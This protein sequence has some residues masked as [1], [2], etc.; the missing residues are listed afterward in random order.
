MRIRLR[1]YGCMVATISRAGSAVRQFDRESS[2]RERELRFGV[3]S[4]SGCDRELSGLSSTDQVSEPTGTCFAF[5]SPQHGER[6][7]RA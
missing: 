7:I 4:A 5:D 1:A 2:S 6:R 3:R